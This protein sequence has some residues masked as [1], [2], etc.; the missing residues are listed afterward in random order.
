[1][2]T[3]FFFLQPYAY[4]LAILL[5]EQDSSLNYLHLLC[6]LGKVPSCLWA[7]FFFFNLNA[8]LAQKPHSLLCFVLFLLW[9]SFPSQ[10]PWA[11]IYQGGM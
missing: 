11:S 3:P 4:S 6:V 2:D 7:M 5:R 1:M 9:V 8:P 10:P